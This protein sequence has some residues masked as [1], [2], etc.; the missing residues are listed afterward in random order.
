MKGGIMTSWISR[1]GGIFEK[2]GGSS[3]KEGSGPPYQLWKILS[4]GVIK[5]YRNQGQRPRNWEKDIGSQH[6]VNMFLNIMKL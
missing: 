5:K 2:G 3:R 4:A 6:C 1:K